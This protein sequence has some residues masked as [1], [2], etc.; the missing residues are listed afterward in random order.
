MVKGPLMKQLDQYYNNDI[1]IIGNKD[2]LSFRVGLT[3]RKPLLHLCAF[4]EAYTTEGGVRVPPY[5]GLR[6]KEICDTFATVMDITF[7]ILEMAGIKYPA[8]VCQAGEIVPM[9]GKSMPQWLRSEEEHTHDG[10]TKIISTAM[11]FAAEALSGKARSNVCMWPA[12]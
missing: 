10:V 7:T 1:E 6:N 4:N 5:P 3:R 8:P 12:C 2:S 11:N 9:R